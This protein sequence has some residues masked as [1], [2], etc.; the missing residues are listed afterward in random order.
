[1]RGHCFSA[2]GISEKWLSLTV[3]VSDSETVQKF[4]RRA[5]KSLKGPQSPPEYQPTKTMSN[6]A[7]HFVI[8][9]GDP[10][11]NLGRQDLD[12]VQG[13]VFCF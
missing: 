3:T 5:D 13:A 1:M 10:Q 2:E 6:E 7:K 12:Y 11:I 4:T 9:V 8:T